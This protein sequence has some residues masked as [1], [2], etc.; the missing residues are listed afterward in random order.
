M[1]IRWK[2]D[3]VIPLTDSKLIKFCF[4]YPIIFLIVAFVMVGYGVYFFH[5][6]MLMEDGAILSVQLGRLKI[7]YEVA[8]KWGVAGFF[9][10]IAFAIAYLFWYCAIKKPSAKTTV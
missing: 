4:R 8:G 7:L 5:R 3:A 2:N 9:F 10:F 1:K 6:I